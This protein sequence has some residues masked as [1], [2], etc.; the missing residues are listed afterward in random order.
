MEHSLSPLL[1]AAAYQAL[2]LDG[3]SYGR[4][5]VTSEQLYYL[6]RDLDDDF[7][8]LSLTM[9]LKQ[10]VIGL[11]DEV[12]PLAADLRSVNTVV[13]TR[14]KKKR[15]SWGFNT[16]VH[17]VVEAL[18]EGF[19]DAGV[20]GGTE[21]S[22]AAVLGAGATAASTLAA[23]QRL[24]CEA[25]TVYARSIARTADLAAVAER[26]GVQ[27]S[28]VPLDEAPSTLAGHAVLVSTLPPGAADFLVP[29]LADRAVAGVLLD[30]A[31]D[32]RR[33]P[34]S[35]AWAAAG[36]VAV[37]GERMLLHQASEQVRLMT[38]RPGPLDA[39]DAALGESLAAR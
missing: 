28:F 11:L 15:V 19:R 4:Q 9:P 23:L 22:D 33:S 12:E 26:L 36:G 21:V 35:D 39:M 8:G 5:D 32:P 38:G 25:P 34:L 31:Y 17:G 3:W 24:G 1:H 29:A 7:A 13:F 10:T 6:L 18:R 37:D 27:P 30:V 20:D 2:G 16:D 14:E